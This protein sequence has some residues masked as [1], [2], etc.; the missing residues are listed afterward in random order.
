MKNFFYAVVLFF[1]II[2]FSKNISIAQSQVYVSED[3][4]TKL[5]VQ[6]NNLENRQKKL[7][8][9]LDTLKIEEKLNEII[10]NQEKII[11]ELKKIK[12]RI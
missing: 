8:Q 11:R 2:F 5:S 3:T 1:L 4:L 7:M 6:L 12:V 10:A 9:E